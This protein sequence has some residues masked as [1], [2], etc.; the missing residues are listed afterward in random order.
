MAGRAAAQGLPPVGERFSDALVLNGGGARG[1]YQAGVIAALAAS[2][3]IVDGQPLKPYGVVCG[4]SIGALN[5]WMVATGQY[6]RL[7]QFWRGIASENIFRLKPQFRAIQDKNSGLANR[8]IDAMHLLTG[9]RSD[10]TGVLESEPV[11]AWLAANVDP[12]QPVLMP[13]AWTSTNLN[14]QRTEYFY[15]VPGNLPDWRKRRLLAALR[16][17]IGPSTVLWEVPDEYLHKALF[18][19]AAIPVAFDPVELA[20][21][22]GAVHQYVDGGVAANSPIAFARTI[23]RSLQVI[24]LDPPFETDTYHSAIEIGLAVFGTMQRRLIENDVRAVFL[25]TVTSRHLSNIDLAGIQTK[26]TPEDK[27]ALYSFF[28]QMGD[29]QLAYIRPSEV[30]PVRVGGFDDGPH[31]I[32]AMR[33]GEEAARTGFTQY[34]LNDF[35]SSR[36]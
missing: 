35:I 20:I 15:R 33:L 4:T 36:A 31:I 22:G 18:A 29:T 30:L 10:V 21:E 25:Q 11:L 26:L 2:A 34:T 6:G 12:K 13:F 14:L 32:E 17:T 5:G 27:L 16:A 1:A 24:L 8:I 19:S 7:Q 23:A 9:M 28:E 3:G